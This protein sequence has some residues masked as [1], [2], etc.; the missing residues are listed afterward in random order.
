MRLDKFLCEM[1]IGTRSQMKA[2]I[3]QGLV[4]VN[5]VLVKTPERKI[6]SERDAVAFKGELLTY[7]KFHYYMLNKPSGVVSATQDEK[8]KTVLD[9]FPAEK[10]KGLFPVGRLD[11]DTVGLLLITDDG[12]LAHSLLSPRKHVDKT[13]LV[14][15][16]FP[17]SPQAL[18]AL[19]EGV[20][21]GEK[22]P[23]LPAKAVLTD[24]R[25]LL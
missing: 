22:H 25:T 13:Y 12:S 2:Y 7:Q 4:T 21:I 10:R 11:K 15:T 5:G 9:F 19:E 14:Q 18:K 3:R 23:T 8:E 1:N 6:D 16:R 17:V 24:E 20:D